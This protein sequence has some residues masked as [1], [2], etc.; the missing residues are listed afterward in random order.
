M[1]L[2]WVRAEKCY[3]APESRKTVKERVLTLPLGNI[4]G[5]N[6]TMTAGDSSMLDSPS[7]ARLRWPLHQCEAGEVLVVHGICESEL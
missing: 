4:Q 2:L 7:G 5:G 3:G 1:S 6:F